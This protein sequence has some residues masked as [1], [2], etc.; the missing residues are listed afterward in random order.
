[1]PAGTQESACGY[2]RQSAGPAG[3]RGDFANRHNEYPRVEHQT[4]QSRFGDHLDKAVVR[5]V[6]VTVGHVPRQEMHEVAGADPEQPMI[7][8]ESEATRPDVKSFRRLP[9]NWPSA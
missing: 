7:H 2:R 4:R 3:D 9:T 1:M 6:H 5:P 8:S